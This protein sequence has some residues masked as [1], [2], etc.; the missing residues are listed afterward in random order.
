MLGS[1]YYEGEGIERDY[2]KAFKNF[3]KVAKRMD[4]SALHALGV[5]Y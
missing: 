3:K 1:C 2:K 4:E 5:C